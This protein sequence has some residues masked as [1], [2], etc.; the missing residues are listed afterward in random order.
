MLWKK[1][2]ITFVNSA[3]KPSVVCLGCLSTECLAWRLFCLSAGILCDNDPLQMYGGCCGWQQFPQLVSYWV[4]IALVLQSFRKV[5]QRIR[6]RSSTNVWW[7]LWMLVLTA[8]NVILSFG[9]S[10]IAVFRSQGASAN[11]LNK[12]KKKPFF[13]D[14]IYVLQ[15]RLSGNLP[16]HEYQF[17][18]E[19]VP[20]WVTVGSQMVLS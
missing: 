13:K 7:M 6:E 20:R 9:R 18:K 5:F 10:S 12:K 16:I 19:T 14:K 8:A 11:S 1:E 17:L 4:L 15:Q 2:R 3:Q